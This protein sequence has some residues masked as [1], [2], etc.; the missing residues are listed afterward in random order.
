MWVGG[1]A[2]TRSN[3]TMIPKLFNWVSNLCETQMGNGQLGPVNNLGLRS[4][5]SVNGNIHRENPRKEGLSDNDFK[6]DDDDK[7]LGKDATESVNQNGPSQP[8]PGRRLRGDGQM[9]RLNQHQNVSRGRDFRLQGRDGGEVRKQPD[10]SSVDKFGY[11][12]GNKEDF[13]LNKKGSRAS[14]SDLFNKSQKD[15]LGNAQEQSDFLEKFKLSGMGKKESSN[16]ENV[17][18]AP[19]DEEKEEPPQDAD[20]IFKRMKET[21]LIPN[22]VAMLDGLCKDGLVQEAMKL[23][24]LMREKGSMP[25]VVI[26]TAVVDGFFQAHKVD[27]AKRIFRKMQSNGITPNAFTYGVLIKGLSKCRR[28]E[29]AVEFC[30]EMMEAGHTPNAATFT[31]LVDVFCKEKGVEEARKVIDALKQKG[32]FLDEKSVREHLNKKGTRSAMV[33]EAIF[34]LKKSGPTSF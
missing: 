5:S 19:P 24:G 20:I 23:F 21:G 16:P 2:S 7:F 32:F 28:L 33:W 12:N 3:L 8:I 10:F 30:M 11:V 6:N 13:G 14:I 34:G 17:A 9:P 27:D 29:E 25:E 31:E 1:K 4:I 26:Y 15:P 18:S 22:A